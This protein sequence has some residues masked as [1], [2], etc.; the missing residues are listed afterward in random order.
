MRDSVKMFWGQK[1]NWLICCEQKMIA[2]TL[3]FIQI[4]I[5][6]KIIKQ[7]FLY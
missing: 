2:F 3:S 5:G 6:Y 7:Y 4:Q 1:R